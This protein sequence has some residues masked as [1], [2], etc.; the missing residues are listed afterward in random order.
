VPISPFSLSF[1]IDSGHFATVITTITKPSWDD[2][3]TSGGSLLLEFEFQSD[4]SPS[5]L[6]IL[7]LWL[8]FEDLE[9]YQLMIRFFNFIQICCLNCFV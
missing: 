1:S 9:M 8:Q 7:E 6:Q 5:S 2:G 3:A 4:M